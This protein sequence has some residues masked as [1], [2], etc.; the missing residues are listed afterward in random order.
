MN[1]AL[2]LYI[3]VYIYIHIYVYG[4]RFLICSTN[5]FKTIEFYSV[6]CWRFKLIQSSL[7]RFDSILFICM[8]R[9]DP[10]CMA[11]KGMSSSCAGQVGGT[12]VG[13]FSV[14][15]GRIEFDRMEPH[16]IKSNWIETERTG[17]KW[18][19]N[20]KLYDIKENKTNGYIKPTQ[21][22]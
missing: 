6:Q 1:I 3:Y 15:K 19:G 20:M 18:T 17:L 21:N 9:T 5:Q 4:Y 2:S 10:P 8:W 13:V 7:V 22:R 11:P 12:R 16:W 14:M